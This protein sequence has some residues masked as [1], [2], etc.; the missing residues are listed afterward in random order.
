MP[1]NARL[2]SSFYRYVTSVNSLLSLIFSWFVH[3]KKQILEYEIKNSGRNFEK[4]G[5]REKTKGV[6][7]CHETVINHWYF[8]PAQQTVSRSKTSFFLSGLSGLEKTLPA[9][10]LFKLGSSS[11]TRKATLQPDRTIKIRN[12]DQRIL[13]RSQKIIDDF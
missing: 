10:L 4:K 2:S 7:N 3:R 6:K 1:N 13:W 9:R 5:R 11:S 8:F 12:D